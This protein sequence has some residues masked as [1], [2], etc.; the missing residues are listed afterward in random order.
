[1]DS[2]DQITDTWFYWYFGKEEIVD[3]ELPIVS[4]LFA[5]N[6]V[7]TILDLG[8]G[9]GR[10]SIFLAKEGFN[11]YGFDQSENAI[12]RAKEL[13]ESK[14]LHVNFK[15]WNM[16]DIPTRLKTLFSMP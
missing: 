14:K 6:C 15:V 2:Q 1:L 9:T 3:P 8:C 13:T 10:H 7:F 5:T 16:T 4:E 11:V 12:K